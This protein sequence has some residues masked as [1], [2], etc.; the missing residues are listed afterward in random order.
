M[1]GTTQQTSTIGVLGGQWRASVSATGGV[2]PWDGSAALDWF[3]AAD[4]RWHIPKDEP[5]VRQRRIDGAPVIE[6]RIKVPNGDA[7][8]RVWCVAD[9]GG[10]TV[11]EIENDSSL[12]FA[13]AFNR[14]DLLSSRPP[15]AV[16]IQG[17]ELPE[18]S[19]VLPVGH[20][21]TVRVALSH[22]APAAGPLP[23]R[24]SSPMQVA[25]GWTAVIDAAGRMVLPDDGLLDRVAELRGE[26]ALNG[27][28]EPD[29]DVIGFLVDVGQLVRLGERADPWVPDVATAVARAA[30]L[31]PTW[32]CAAALDA[33]GVVL[34]R[35]GETRAL[36]DLIRL[37]S[38]APTSLPTAAP[39]GRELLWIEQRLARTV[40]IGT[41]D[42]L[43]A[44]IPTAW[45]GANF[46]VYGLPIGP[47]TTVSYAVRW[48]GDR[49]AILWETDGPTVPL[50]ASVIAPEWSTAEP[51]GEALWPAPVGA[52]A[53]MSMPTGDIS[54]N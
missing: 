29:E 31:D 40:G 23:E 4:D 48:H 43:G 26:L 11:V 30:R 44:G 45:L 54:F 19:V 15:A 2:E 35:A 46:E 50:T 38:T 7:I 10:Y 13:V 51:K 53:I 33:A 6:T 42:L 22:D 1:T 17:I 37:R 20:K 24:L 14:A 32:D 34:A 41:A 8:H 47:S 25:R 27:P 16:P 18:H 3:I 21:S 28:V 12:P 52:S 9:G 39:D 49:P 5:T 36:R